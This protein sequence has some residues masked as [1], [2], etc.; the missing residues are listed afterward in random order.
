M[1]K[2]PNTTKHTEVCLDIIVTKPGYYIMRINDLN[3]GIKYFVGSGE[4]VS[5]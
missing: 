2:L 5:E 3:I 1:K 4:T